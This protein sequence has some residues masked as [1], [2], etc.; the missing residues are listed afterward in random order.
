VNTL[1]LGAGISGGAAAGLAASLG[2]SV[3]VYDRSSQATI[4]LRDCGYAIHSGAWADRLLSR[5]DLVVV[6]P[7]FP[8][9]SDPVLRAQAAGI[10]VISELEFGTQQLAVPYVAVTGTNGKTTVTTAIAAMLNESGVSAVAAGN[11]GL[12]VCGLGPDPASVVVLEA[13][14]FQ[15]RFI[16]RF[17]PVAAGITNVAAD[18]LDWH[19]T[20]ADYAAAKARIFENMGPEE[21]VVYDLDDAGATELATQARSRTLAVSGTVVPPKGIGPDGGVLVVG[22]SRLPIATTDPSFVA[23][24]G[25]AAAIAASVGASVAGISAVL[26]GFTPGAHRRRPVGRKDGILWIDD[27]KATNP[28]AARAAAAAYENV[29]LLAGGRNKDLDLSD[30]ATDTVHHVVAFGEAGP[31]VAD[32]V[33]VPVTVVA[34]LE[35]AVHAA[36]RIAQSG[37]TVLLAPGCASFDEFESYAARGDRFAELVAEVEASK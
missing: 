3:S 35:E 13:S 5:I 26:A 2:Q 12:P 25:I 11:I 19:R 4:P 32:G 6:S 37:D 27:S 8:E 7:G 10:E 21:L 36:R 23:D 15:L 22:A 33:D 34:T 20:F 17:H 9:H 31:D 24:L 18:H 16:D 1:I 29:V 14:S 30:L 28:H